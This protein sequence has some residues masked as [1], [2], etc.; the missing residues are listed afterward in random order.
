[1][2]H[3]SE[4]RAEPNL[5]PIL[6]MVFQLITFFMLV[7]NFKVAAI[8]TTLSLPVVGSARPVD[9]KGADLLVLNVDKQGDLKVYGRTITD[10]PKYI[11][12]EAKASLKLARKDNP[13]LKPGDDL[14]TTI[15]IRADKEI[16]FKEL[17]K[18]ISQ[19]QQ[20]G[21]RNYSL[22]TLEKPKTKKT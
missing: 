19:C 12:D 15:V 1:M 2:S 22:K 20:N 14:P 18:V 17:Y 7:I 10:I 3:E 16:R 8:D 6:D 9:F 13:E 5:T 21:Y 11:A 4:N